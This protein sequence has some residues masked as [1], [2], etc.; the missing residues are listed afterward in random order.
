MALTKAT[1]R[2][3]SGAPKNVKDFGAVGDGTTNDQAAIQAAIDAGDHIYFPAGTYIVNI[4]LTSYGTVYDNPQNGRDLLFGLEIKGSNKTIYSDGQAT[5]KL[6]APSSGATEYIAYGIGIQKTSA[7]SNIVI[8][9]LSIDLDQSTNS[10]R[11]AQIRGLLIAN[12]SQFK[13][14]NCEIFSQTLG[15]YSLSLYD[16]ESAVIDNCRFENISG[17][18]NCMWCNDT[19]IN[20]CVFEGFNEAIDLDK[21]N[22]GGTISGCLFDGLGGAGEA[23]DTNSQRGL[24]IDGNIFR[25]FT[26]AAI[27]MNGK[28]LPSTFATGYADYKLI[29]NVTTSG[30]N[31]VITSAGHG[32]TN[33]NVVFVNGVEGYSGINNRTAT[34]ANATT[35]TFEL[36]G[37]AGSGTYTRGGAVW[38]N[39]DWGWEDGENISVTG[40]TF[41]GVGPVNIGNN[42]SGLVNGGT[43]NLRDNGDPTNNITIASN[44]FQG[45]DRI[46]VREGRYI[47]ISNNN[48]V[49]STIGGAGTN[50]AAIQCE[51]ETDTTT[52][53]RAL[54]DSDCKVTITGNNIQNCSRNGIVLDNPSDFV[55]SNNYI[56]NTNTDAGTDRDIAVSG[57]DT[58]NPSG[59]IEANNCIAHTNSYTGIQVNVG[60]ASTAKVKMKS[61][62]VFEGA[63]TYSNKPL[64]L[65]GSEVFPVIEGEVRSIYQPT[66]TAANMP[67]GCPMGVF[68]S[69]VVILRLIGVTE[70]D[71][72][73][74][75]TDYI[76][77]NFQRVET[78]GSTN[79]IGSVATTE[80]TGLDFNARVP[81]DMIAD[82]T[83]DVDQEITRVSVG[84]SLRINVA[85]SGAGQDLPIS[86][87]TAHYVEF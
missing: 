67:Q 16:T 79:S 52:Y 59:V 83:G 38:D 86:N 40:N 28:Y 75:N 23:I 50:N 72:T 18:I 30:S 29:T 49:N 35:N 45:F 19:T 4:P 63:S 26:G 54:L 41:R 69:N 11:V 21:V 8:N 80:T 32:F 57:L 82:I 62:K 51:S 65:N 17:G 56:R 13:L 10:S 60:T 68:P 37:V 85:K 22:I 77:F 64:I 87:F 15:G 42:W 73:Q 47:T 53:A 12:T 14:Q 5:I 20:N 39:T 36:S 34:V 76:Q 66:I 1:Y 44:S 3:T 61:N 46:Y 25:N 24:V 27:W 84:E 71:I 31:A 58:R 70:A 6:V 48:F 78:D 43:A 81:V 2:M 7:L 9:G 74:D 33:G 55:V